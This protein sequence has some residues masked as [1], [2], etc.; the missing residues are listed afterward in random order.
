MDEALIA[1]RL[2]QFASA[3]L[4]FGVTAFQLYAVAGPEPAALSALDLRLRWLLLVSATAAL[5]SALALVPLIGGMMAGSIAAGFD[6]A[7][8]TT[9][10]SNT[11]FGRVWSWHLLISA[12]LVVAGA[13]RRVRPA[14][15]SVLAALVLASL[16]WVGHAVI[17][18]GP[19]GLVHEINDSV[20]L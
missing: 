12:L 4:A 7:T 8:I 15:R 2:V 1:L 19:V 13:V 11:S 14:Y 20:H 17:G 3:T 6:L 5:L 10:L 18:E 9:V 16:G